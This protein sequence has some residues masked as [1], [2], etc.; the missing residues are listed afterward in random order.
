[1]AGIEP[2]KPGFEEIILQPRVD[3]RTAS[4]LPDGQQRMTDVKASY[5][6]AAG[7]IESE[8]HNADGFTYRCNI[9]VTAELR[10]PIFGDKLTVNGV[11][12]SFGEY[13]NDN[14]CAIIR[15]A[16]GEYVFEEM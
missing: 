16:P 6:S 3:T 4:E 12:H 7:L 9:P 1:M 5:K 13:E 10:L 2:G 15:L 11:E 8:W 14:G